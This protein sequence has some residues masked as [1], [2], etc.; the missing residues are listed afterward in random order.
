MKLGIFIFHKIGLLLKITKM[1][2][3]KQ[4]KII[5]KRSF[6]ITFL[7][8]QFLNFW[9]ST[10]FM[11]RKYLR[12]LMQGFSSC[13]PQNSIKYNLATHLVMKLQVSFS[14]SDPK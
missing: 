7:T 2:N 3:K 12:S 13:D 14:V 9:F 6:K 5:R 4:T 1:L 10:I 8:I 11:Q